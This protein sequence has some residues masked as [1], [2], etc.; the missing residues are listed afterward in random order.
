MTL[1]AL[2]T[3][4][5]LPVSWDGLPV[6]WGPWHSGR[7]SLELHLRPAD[8]ACRS[9]GLIE[10]PLVAAGTVHPLPGDTVEGEE[11]VTLPS[12]RTHRRAVTVPA[13]PRLALVAFRCPGCHHDQVYDERTDETW[14]LDPSDYGE[15]GSSPEGALW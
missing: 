12:G 7:S 3:M 2:P 13:G 14:D 5:D 1:R 10:S 15:A 6:T 8:I 9:C 4:H 11:V